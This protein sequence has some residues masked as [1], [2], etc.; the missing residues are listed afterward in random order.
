MSSVHTMSVS[1]Y[2]HKVNEVLQTQH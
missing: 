2:Q 1:N